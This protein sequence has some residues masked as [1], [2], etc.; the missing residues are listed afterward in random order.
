MVEPIYGQGFFQ[1]DPSGHILYLVIFDYRDEEE[2]YFKLV[3][4]GGRGLELEEDRLRR[5]MQEL[6]DE[7]EVLIN[8][9]RARV[10]VLYAAI[11]VRGSP[12]ISS[13]AFLSLIPFNPRRG[14][15]VYENIYDPTTA[16]YDYTV[17]WSIRCG[18]I[19]RVESPG[20]VEVKGGRATIRVA[21][22]TSIPGYESVVF[23]FKD[24]CI[25]RLKPP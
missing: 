17:Y 18:E 15:N 4:E 24:E 12:R 10:E 22:G 25:A 9:E 23:R 6:M 2:E 5:R 14:S 11:D 16:E 20:H 1:V 3:K 8:G 19:V 21:K 13:A 7:E